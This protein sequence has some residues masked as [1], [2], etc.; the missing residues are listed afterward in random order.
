MKKFGP[1]VGGRLR[2]ARK[3]ANM[4]SSSVASSSYVSLEHYRMMEYGEYYPNSNIIR[5]AHSN[6]WDIDYIIVGIRSCESVFEKY[7]GSY[8][9]R[10]YRY[11][12]IQMEMQHIM[13]SSPSDVMYVRLK[14]EEETPI[15]RLKYTIANRGYE[16]DEKTIANVLGISTRTVSRMRGDCESIKVDMMISAYENCGI[17]PSYF[18]YGEIN[19]N[20]ECDVQYRKMSTEQR[21]SI[22]KYAEKISSV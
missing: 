18:L 1:E 6:R 10:M 13:E 7:L 21:R 16:A 2:E 19:S 11:Q 8:S 12:Q 14:A 5:Y 3:T 4:S 20:S 22:I 15:D 17:F 9:N